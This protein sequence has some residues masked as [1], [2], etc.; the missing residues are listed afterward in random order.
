M[1]SYL[2]LAPSVFSLLFFVFCCVPTDSTAQNKSRKPSGVLV[3]ADLSGKI[4]R[5]NSTKDHYVPASIIKIATASYAL[6]TFGENHAFSTYFYIT[7]G[8]D[9]VIRGAGDPGFTSRDLEAACREL[10]KGYRS[11]NRIIFDTTFYA[12]ELTVPGRGGSSN[13]YDAPIGPLAINYNTVAILKHKDGTVTSGEA[14]TPLTTFAGRLAKSLA[15]G[16]H[17]VRVGNDP[18]D[19]LRQLYEL[20]KIFLSREGVRVHGEYLIKKTPPESSMIYT[21]VS[22]KMLRAHVK[23]MLLYS[24]NFIANQLFYVT[25]AYYTGPPAK[26]VSARQSFQKFL[27][28]EIGFQGTFT[29]EEGAGLS[30]NNRITISQGIKMLKYFYPYRDLLVE[31]NGISYKSG[32]LTGVSNLAGYHYSQQGDPLLFLYF[33]TAASAVSD[34]VRR[35]SFLM[36]R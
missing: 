7:P 31:E 19:G 33:D 36:K 6:F 2:R 14:E 18:S 17:R 16:S 35:V 12:D 23:D 15:P 21:Y 22:P 10:A 26:F 24:N 28:R 1:L 13:P 11:F 4:L 32:T 29:V 20:T 5:N 25:S 27:E 34:R 30:R 3:T 8:N 9:L